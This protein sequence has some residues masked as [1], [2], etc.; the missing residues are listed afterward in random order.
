MTT[1]TPSV[2]LVSQPLSQK[3]DWNS[4]TFIVYL[5]VTPLNDCPDLCPLSKV[6]KSISGVKAYCVIGYFYAF[7]TMWEMELTLGKAQIVGPDYVEELDVDFTE[8]EDEELITSV[9]N[10]KETQIYCIVGEAWKNYEGIRIFTNLLNKI[11]DKL[12]PT[13]WKTAMLYP[14]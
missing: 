3:H 12:F 8:R 11:K 7:L 4:A 5:F 13:V 1:Q 9:I 6:E 10:K 14:I 2:S